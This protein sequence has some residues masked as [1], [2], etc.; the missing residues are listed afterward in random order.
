MAKQVKFQS[1]FQ[2]PSSIVTWEIF[3]SDMAISLSCG[4]IILKCVPFI[5]LLLGSYLELNKLKSIIYVI[6]T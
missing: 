1:K 6:Q 3:S 4:L 2:L 5:G